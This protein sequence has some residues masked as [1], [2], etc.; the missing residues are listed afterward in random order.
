ME[1]YLQLHSRLIDFATPRVMA[2]VNLSVDSFY[3]SCDVAD[4]SRLLL[5][6]EKM[7][8][9]GADILD[10]GACSTRPN[11]TPVTCQEEWHL[12]AQG[13]KIIIGQMLRYRLIRSGQT[14]L[15]WLS[16]MVRI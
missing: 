8:Q 1:K 11:S 13:L 15:S 2:I 9:Q 7:L 6:V 16:S 5:Q 4:E 14:L 12:L 3:T 10:L